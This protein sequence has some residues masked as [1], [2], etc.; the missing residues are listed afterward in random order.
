[1]LKVAVL[2]AVLVGGFGMSGMVGYAETQTGAKTL[3]EAVAGK[4]LIGGAVMSNHLDDPKLAA[5]IKRELTTLTGENDFKPQSVQPEKGKFNF[6]AA[7]KI[8]DFCDQNGIKLVGHTLVWHSQAPRFLFEDDAGKPLARDVA[9]ANLKAHIDAVAGRYK[10][11][12]I[13]WDVVNEAISD[14]PNEYLRNTPAL[15]A[16]GPDYL[17]MAFKYAAQAD[18]GAELYYNDYSNE[19]KEKRDKCIRLIRELKAAGCRVDAIGIQGHWMMEGWPSTQLVDEAIKAYAAE[20]VKVMITELDVDPLPRQTQGAAV[21]AREQAAN[22]YP[23]DLPPDM[24]EKLAKRYGELFEVFA[25]NG[26]VVSRITLWG[27]HDGMS[28]LNNWPVRGRTN[29]G[30][31]W[32]RAYNPKPAYEAVRKQLE[33]WEK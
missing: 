29:H 31:L 22:P 33:R 26:N 9:L 30:L 2:L 16:I 25:K 5:L 15:R 6:E 28:W 11:R 4:T 10:G 8:A 17:A 19:N 24:Q 1:M 20:G 18:P 27:T 14:S 12:V 7:D 3:K 32:D 13:G 23:K 21:D